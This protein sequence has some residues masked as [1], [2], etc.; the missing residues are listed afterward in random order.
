MQPLREHCDSH[1]RRCSA[2]RC[3]GIVETIAGNGTAGSANGGAGQSTIHYPVAVVTDA[4]GTIFFTTEDT[5]AVRMLT[6][7]GARVA[8]AV[9]TI[10]CVAVTVLLLFLL[11]LFCNAKS[12]RK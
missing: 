3:A 6:A 7:D 12:K 5:Y 11:I 4:A 8:N 2:V 10:R 1:S 9:L